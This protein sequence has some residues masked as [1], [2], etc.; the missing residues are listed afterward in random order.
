MTRTCRIRILFAFTASLIC[1]G[2]GGGGTPVAGGGAP[3]PTPSPTPSPTPAS[4]VVWKTALPP[5]QGANLLSLVTVGS[6]VFGAGVKVDPSGTNTNVYASS[7]IDNGTSATPGMPTSLSEA[8][9]ISGM[10][11]LNSTTAF[12]VGSDTPAGSA[13]VIPSAFTLDPSNSTFLSVKPFVCPAGSTLAPVLANPFGATAVAQDGTTMWVALRQKNDVPE[14]VKTDLA[15]SLDCSQTAIRVAQGNTKGTIH[16]MIATSTSLV[17][18][19]EFNVGTPE[20]FLIV[21]DKTS[22]TQTFALVTGNT[23]IV[24]VV[25]DASGSIYTAGQQVVSQPN[26]WTIQKFSPPFTASNS[27]PVWATKAITPPAGQTTNADDMV[28]LS[29]DATNGRLIA[30]GQTTPT[31]V[32]D[33]NNVQTSIAV[34]DPATGAT[35][36]T[37]QVNIFPGDQEHVGSA[38]LGPN[39]A[40]Y[41]AGEKF[42][43]TVGNFG[44]WVAKISLQ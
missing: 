5:A 41:V 11:L 20:G 34:L 43:P 7:V 2:C 15:G 3:T 1:M 4:A 13:S 33:V 30:V 23:P 8:S 31:G 12:A 18:G 24:G 9:D 19:G 38:A 29:L 27:A 16:Q 17:L 21:I 6:T 37:I 14:I 42:T 28:A 26:F 35:I 44:A 22:G 39:N 10:V 40:L 36:K 32:A 25:M